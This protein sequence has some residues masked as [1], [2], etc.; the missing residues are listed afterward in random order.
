[1]S[2][3]ETPQKTGHPL[4]LGSPSSQPQLKVLVGAGG[5]QYPLTISGGALAAIWPVGKPI[6][7]LIKMYCGG[8]VPK[9]TKT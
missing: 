4:P 8:G 7:V 3:L 1:M 5:S 9:E 2:R 6:L